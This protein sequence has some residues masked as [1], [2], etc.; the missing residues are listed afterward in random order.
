M[1]RW[2]RRGVGRKRSA[3]SIREKIDI[4]WNL[5][6][7]VEDRGKS[8]IW[9]HRTHN[10]VVNTGEQFMAEVITPA[11]LGP[12]GSFTREQDNIIRYIGFG[13][14][15]T[16]QNS[17]DASASPLSDTY[18]AG[19]DGGNSQTDTDPTVAQLERPVLVTTGPDLFMQEISTPGTFAA[20]NETTF[21]A[22]FSRTEINVG[23]FT[24]V[25]LSEIGLYL[26]SADPTLPNGGAGAYPGGT[27]HLAAYDTFDSIS[28]TG[29][30][31]ITVRWTWRF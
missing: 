1:M 16:R 14:G 25:P 23:A 4:R 21:I 17:S 2:T 27:G 19:Y 28:K 11:T 13:I 6:I 9:H 15:G 18:P 7:S 30:F 29:G 10:I 24:S 22:V 20:F 26:N 3:F 31:Q 12:S 5:Q 8:K